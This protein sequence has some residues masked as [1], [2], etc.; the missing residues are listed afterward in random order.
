[1]IYT[2]MKH[3]KRTPLPFTKT[4]YLLMLVG[5]LLIGLG[6]LTMALDK[7]PHGFGILGLTVGPIMVLSGYLIEFW[8]ILYRSQNQQ[9]NND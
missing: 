8:A 4:N 1:M 5:I 7:N 6:Y 9:S 2:S 3:K